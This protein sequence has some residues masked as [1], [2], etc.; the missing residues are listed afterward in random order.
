MDQESKYKA[1]YHPK[2][3]LVLKPVAKE[4][5]MWSVALERTMLTYFEIDPKSRFDMHSHASEQITLVL[6][7]ELFFDVQDRI[8]CLKKGDVI[9]LPSNI[10]HAAFTKDVAV[11]A[12]DAWSPVMKKYE[13]R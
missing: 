13:D 2:K 1:K 5:Q 4:A 6:Q 11:K 7:G 12:V 8:I 9:A 10:P 3:S